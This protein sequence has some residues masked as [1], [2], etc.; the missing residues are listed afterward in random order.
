MKINKK[1]GLIDDIE[2][3]SSPNADERPEDRD[4]ELIVI[5]NIRRQPGEFGGD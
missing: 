4:P 2:Y 1:T 3:I 5:H